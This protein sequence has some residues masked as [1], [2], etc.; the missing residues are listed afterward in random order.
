MLQRRV[1]E[2]HLSGDTL[3]KTGSGGLGEADAWLFTICKLDAGR[4]KCPL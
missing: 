1:P 2:R 3:Q 4:L